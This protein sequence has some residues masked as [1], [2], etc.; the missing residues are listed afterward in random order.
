MVEPCVHALNTM[1]ASK[2][3]LSEA[4]ELWIELIQ[5]MPAGDGR[6]LASNRGRQLLTSGLALCANC[7]DPRFDFN[8]Q[9]FD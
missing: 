6:Q 2:R 8:Q 3:T 4:V 1:Q 9:F 7:L 5:R